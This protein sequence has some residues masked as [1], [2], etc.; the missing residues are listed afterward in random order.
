MGE[1]ELVSKPG[2]VAA[3]GLLEAGSVEAAAALARPA[4]LD[5]ADRLVLIHARRVQLQLV[6]P[7][8][9]ARVRVAHR[10]EAVRR[11][12]LDQTDGSHL[13]RA[14]CARGD[15]SGS[16]AVSGEHGL[17]LLV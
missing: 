5:A 17:Q 9:G 10:V 11:G 2:V 16:G 3:T 12:R 7:L 13:P 15:G 4:Q 1:E 6:A 14:Q 8:H